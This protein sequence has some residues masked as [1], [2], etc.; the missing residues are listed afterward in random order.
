MQQANHSR[1]QNVAPVSPVSGDKQHERVIQGEVLGKENY[2]TNRA[3]RAGFTINAQRED[4]PGFYSK[5]YQ[6]PSKA[7]MAIDLYTD[8]SQLYKNETNSTIDYFV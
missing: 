3:D 2:R 5:Q 1:V 8:T 7:R 6:D 4:H